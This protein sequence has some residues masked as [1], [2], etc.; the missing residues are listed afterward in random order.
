MKYVIMADGIG[1]RWNNHNDIPKHL[2]KINDETLLERTVRLLKK[3]DSAS[4]IIITSHNT[5]YNVND[6]KRYEPLNNILEIDRFT[7][8]LIEDNVCF[9]Y[10][11]TI[12]QEYTIEIIVKSPT[13]E[14][15][16]FGNKDSIVC[17]KVSNAKIFIEHIDKVKDLYINNKIKNCIGWQVYQSYCNLMF[18]D[19]SINN[20]AFI[21]VSNVFNIN[22]PK[23]L[24]MFKNLIN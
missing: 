16:F 17:V 14:L 19:K 1:K 20:K 2:I 11:D 18:N 4:E 12:Y 8:E 24:E 10:G 7:Y 3:Y 15:L 6:A 5:N 23:D 9:L 21:L 22:S 13:K